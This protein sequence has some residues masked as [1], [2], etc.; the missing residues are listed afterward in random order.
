MDKNKRERARYLLNDEVNKATED[1]A[2]DFNFDLIESEVLSYCNRLDF[3]PGLMLIVIK[4]VA[5]YT[6]AEYYRSKLAEEKTKPIEE[7]GQ[8]VSSISRGDTT[9]SYGDNAKVI[10]FGTPM[11]A[12]I[13][14]N[15]FVGNYTDQIRKY[16]KVRTPW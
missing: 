3:P 2:L 7:T 13:A 1:E 16:R 12:Y 4:M 10:D 14:V 9:I 5:E 11:N 15:D 6:T 8:S